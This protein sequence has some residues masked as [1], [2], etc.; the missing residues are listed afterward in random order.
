MSK[1]Q[2]YEINLSDEEFKKLKR[3]KQSILL[4]LNDDENKKIT[5][6]LKIILINSKNKKLKKKVKSIKL[7]SNIRE[8]FDNN[9]KKQLGY[10]RKEEV[11]FNDIEKT[12]SKNDLKKYGILAI[13]LKIKKHIFRKILLGVL[14]FI[15]LVVMIMLIKTGITKINNTMFSNAINKIDEEKVNYMFIEINPSFAITIKNNRVNDVACLNDDCVS[16]YDD[17]KIVGKNTNDSIEY[18]FNLAKEKGF[19]T[20]NGVKIRTSNKSDIDINKL[21]YVNIEYIDETT[22]SELL[23]SVKN[24]KK[25]KNIDN[26][27]YYSKLWKRLKKDRD[28]NKYYT[29]D[30]KN[31]KL[32]CYFIMKAITPPKWNLSSEDY[33]G[34]FGNM[35][36]YMGKMNKMESIFNKFGVKTKNRQIDIVL[37]LQNKD[38]YYTRQ[39]TRSYFGNVT[40]YSMILMYED[41]Y[42]NMEIINIEDINLLNINEAVTKSTKIS[43]GLQEEM[44]Q[45][46][47]EEERRKQE[48]QK[49]KEE[50][51]QKEKNLIQKGYTVN[52]EMTKDN[53]N[54]DGSCKSYCLDIEESDN[55]SNTY[56]E[57]IYY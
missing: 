5:E 29:C 42:D 37:K 11:N 48:E 21:N 14:T 46:K 22:E 33:E 17:I 39:F 19:D 51:L 36:D 55:Y 4:R 49:Q 7:Y 30:M 28:Y 35:V 34:I 10:K 38:F 43:S 8:V 41:E 24:N 56:C 44:E 32:E 3:N 52:E 16:I 12:F 45:Q 1:K 57:T 31:K 13:E 47:A 26:D 40:E 27:D 53:C 23:S 6:K 25:I 20:S 18:L 15:L 2:I 54:N 9:K 50:A